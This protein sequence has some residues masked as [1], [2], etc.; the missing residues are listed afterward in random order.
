MEQYYF[1]TLHCTHKKTDS[2]RCEELTM[3][4]QQESDGVNIPSKANR[5]L[6]TTPHTASV[7]TIGSAPGSDHGHLGH[8]EE[9]GFTGQEPCSMLTAVPP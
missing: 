2:C 9:S 4:S 5:L 8:A 3:V 7:T 6:T 1:Y